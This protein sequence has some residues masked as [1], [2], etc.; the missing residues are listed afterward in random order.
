MLHETLSTFD[1]IKCFSC[2]TALNTKTY[3]WLKLSFWLLERGFNFHPCHPSIHPWI[4]YP[5]SCSP[6][7]MPNGRKP[8]LLWLNMHS[9]FIF[10]KQLYIIWKYLL[11]PVL[12]ETVACRLGPWARPL[13]LWRGARGPDQWLS[14]CC[15][16]KLGSQWYADACLKGE[17]EQTGLWRLKNFSVSALVLIQNKSIISSDIS[18][19]R[20]ANTYVWVYPSVSIVK[21]I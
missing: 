15:D 7:Y 20:H 2:S 6:G 19:S 18:L 17:G 5:I 9:L 1:V 14:P 4:L 3:I 13:A 10:Y 16:P 8:F 21:T 11:Y 12:C